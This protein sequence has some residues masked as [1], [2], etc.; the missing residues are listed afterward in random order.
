[1]LLRLVRRSDLWTPW[2]SPWLYGLLAG[3]LGPPGHGAEV[4]RNGRRSATAALR[5]RASARREAR[6]TAL[7]ARPSRSHGRA[8]PRSSAW[9]DRRSQQ[10]FDAPT[11][12]DCRA[13][14]RM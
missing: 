12:A 11:S 8:T 10:R 6:S 2:R 14:N 4:A 1:M 5:D 7:I 9:P 13:A 3:R